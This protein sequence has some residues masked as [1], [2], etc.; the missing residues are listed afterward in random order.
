MSGCILLLS[1]SHSP[2]FLLN[3]CLDLFSAPSLAR[4]DPLSRSYRVSLPSSLTVIHSSALVYSTRLRVSVCGT[5]TLQVMFSG[6]SRQSA[7]LHCH[8]IPEELVYSQG[9]LSPRICLRGSAPTLFNGL[10]RQP[11]AVSLLRLH[12]TLEGSNGILTVSAIGLAVRLSLRSR[13]TLIRLALIR[14]P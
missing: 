8:R 7:Y 9:R 10:F 14:K 1:Y 4:R 13:L 12:V 5:G 2:V 3:S 11:A 6:F